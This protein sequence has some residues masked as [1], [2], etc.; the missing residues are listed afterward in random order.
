MRRQLF[1]IGI[2]YGL[3]FFLM[4][5][6]VTYLYTRK[7]ADATT[8]IKDLMSVNK[9]KA[10]EAIHIFLKKNKIKMTNIQKRDLFLDIML[11]IPLT[12][13]VFSSV[14]QMIES[15]LSPEMRKSMMKILKM[16]MR[17]QQ[18]LYYALKL[19]CGPEYFSVI[20]SLECLDKE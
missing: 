15:E 14:V 5:A 10:D 16:R 11:H 19:G 7:V 1:L 20:K 17:Q 3:F 8:Q 12:E 2:L 9:I 6:S 4:G 13:G 18:D